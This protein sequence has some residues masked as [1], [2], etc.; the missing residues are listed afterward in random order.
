[1]KSIF[2]TIALSALIV[3]CSSPT[4]ETVETAKPDVEPNTEQLSP[5]ETESKFSVNEDGFDKFVRTQVYV[6]EQLVRKQMKEPD[7]TEFRNWSYVKAAESLPPTICGEVTSKNSMDGMTGFRK[8][9][10]KTDTTEFGIE[11]STD[12]FDDIYNEF[13][14][15]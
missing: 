10:I 5:Y 14:V 7:T 1:M 11:K 2:L 4:D 9:L 6:A 15:M 8:F 3:G 13:C 12:G